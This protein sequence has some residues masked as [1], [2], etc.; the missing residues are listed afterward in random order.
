[1]TKLEQAQEILRL[2]KLTRQL[3]LESADALKIAL[4]DPGNS[5]LVKEAERKVAEL[6][7]VNHEFKRKM[8]EWQSN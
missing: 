7:M 6:Q 8:D 3:I 2:Q 5:E 4:A 1:M